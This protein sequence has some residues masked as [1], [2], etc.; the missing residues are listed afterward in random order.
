MKTLQTSAT[1]ADMP[2]GAYCRISAIELDGLM[3]RRILD[4][5]IVP[6]TPVQCVRKSPSGNP[7]AYAVRGSTIALRCEDARLITV[8]PYSVSEEGIS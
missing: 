2:V 7:V 4:I 5:G 3:R 1:L 8:N 6:G